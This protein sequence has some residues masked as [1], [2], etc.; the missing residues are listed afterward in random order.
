MTKIT[1][2]DKAHCFYVGLHFSIFHKM[3]FFF[4]NKKI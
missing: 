4:L 2:E 1:D 3:F